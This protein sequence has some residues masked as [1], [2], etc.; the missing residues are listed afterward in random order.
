[1]QSCTG[2]EYTVPIAE[3]DVESPFFVGRVA[4]L[5]LD[6]PSVP[7]LVGN[8]AGNHWNDIPVRVPV[9]ANPVEICQVRTRAQVK[10]ETEP[11]KL[12][13]GSRGTFPKRQL[14]SSKGCN[15]RI[16]P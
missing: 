8:S 3:V 16:K 6:K 1:M 2:A 12:W 5:V 13:H 9:Y 15:R 11:A 4:V 7:V 10:K 14:R